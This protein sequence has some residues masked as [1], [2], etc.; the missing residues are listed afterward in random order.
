[1]IF[2][3]WNM[4]RFGYLLGGSSQLVRGVISSKWTLP[5]LSQSITRVITYLLS[6]MKHQVLWFVIRHPG[7]DLKWT[8]EMSSTPDPNVLFST[9]AFYLLQYVNWCWLYVV[10]A[11]T[12]HI[13]IYIWICIC[14]C[15]CVCMHVCMCI[16]ICMYIIIHMFLGDWML[17]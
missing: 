12:Y 14:V 17:I 4:E 7:E 3:T 5:P 8:M 16:C 11:Y 10:Y 6:G 9:T 1:M 13:Y 15:L 2:H